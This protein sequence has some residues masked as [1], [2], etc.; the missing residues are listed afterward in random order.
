VVQQYHGPDVVDEG[1]ESCV[2]CDGQGYTYTLMSRAWQKL[3]M[4][5]LQVRLRVARRSRQ[6]VVY[7]N[8]FVLMRDCPF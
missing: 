4:R 1:W 8:A 6:R 3:S 5:R 2:A 7:K